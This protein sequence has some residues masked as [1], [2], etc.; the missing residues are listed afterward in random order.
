MADLFA[1]G[2]VIDIILLLVGLEAA[3][4]LAWRWRRS[5]GPSPVA[6]AANLASGALLMLGLRG[7]LTGADWT[8]IAGC[9]L[10]ALLAH[11]VDL[12]IR[13]RAEQPSSNGT[14]SQSSDPGT[15]PKTVAFNSRQ[16]AG[17]VSS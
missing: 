2:R 5:Q 16:Q 13:L 12:F 6:L 11:L 4:L 7:A 14:R 10:G 8:A 3:A 17:T 15:S 1:S 9:L